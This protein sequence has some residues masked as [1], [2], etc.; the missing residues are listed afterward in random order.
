M[1]SNKTVVFICDSCQVTLLSRESMKNHLEK[2]K[3]LSASEYFIERHGSDS[4]TS[5]TKIQGVKS[6]CSLINTKN[7]SDFAVFCPKCHFC[8]NMNIATCC[9]HY[10]LAHNSD[11]FIYSI[12]KLKKI[13]KIII[14]KV[15]SCFECSL[16][17]K[18]LSDLSYHLENA[19]HLNK[20][21]N[22]ELVVLN[23]PIE[24][25]NFR[26]VQFFTFKQHLL[27]HSYFRS[28]ESLNDATSNELSIPV[29]V[30]VYD[31]PTQI[32][33]I[34]PFTDTLLDLS[35][36]LKCVESLMDFL[37]G[38]N[39]YLDAAK[40]LKSRKDYLIKILHNAPVQNDH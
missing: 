2:Q 25:C 27:S 4:V 34:C 24:D 1:A 13:E 9:L 40:K 18:K 21:P 16:K 31:K 6:R 11:E 33:H 20:N 3:H 29:M 26:T 5:Q 39:D 14:K 28:N 30:H 38:H 10:K 32:F 19:K 8:F 37:K 12:S 7:P 36:E 17:F 35:D 22:S 23:C 15:H